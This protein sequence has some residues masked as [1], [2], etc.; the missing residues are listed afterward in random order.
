VREHAAIGAG[1][2]RADHR[3]RWRCQQLGAAAHDQERRRVGDLGEALRIARLALGDQRAAELGDRRELGLGL[4]APAAPPALLAARR[5]GEP[6]Q[7]LERAGRAAEAAQQLSEGLR[8]DPTR[9]A[10]LQPVDL[11]AL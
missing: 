5:A 7:L 8:P 10:E 6:R 11:L 3:H 4:L 2:A 1:I 9:A